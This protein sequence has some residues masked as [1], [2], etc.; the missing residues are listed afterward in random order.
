M[1]GSIYPRGC[2][3]PEFVDEPGKPI[4]YFAKQLTQHARLA[5]QLDAA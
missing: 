2:E 5:P 4:Q 1:P 3:S